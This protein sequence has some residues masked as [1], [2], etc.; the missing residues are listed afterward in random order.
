MNFPFA[1]APAPSVLEAITFWLLAGMTLTSAW[2]TVRNPNLF[3]AGLS[4]ICCFL[5]VAGLYVNLGAPF[6]G[7]M[8]V[9]IYA[10]AIAVLL[11]FAFMLTHDLMKPKDE[12]FQNASGAVTALAMAAMLVFVAVKSE[13]RAAGSDPV[14]FDPAALATSYMHDNLVPFEV[15]SLLLLSALVGAL[16]IARKE[17]AP[18]E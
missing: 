13:W 1:D 4:L 3:H 17:E 10:G 2:F 16:M 7:A 14:K 8:Q 18:P 5:G 15:V 11:L 9:L 12:R 6:L